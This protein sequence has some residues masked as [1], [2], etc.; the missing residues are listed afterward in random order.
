MGSSSSQYENQ[1]ADLWSVS[2]WQMRDPQ[3]QPTAK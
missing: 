3:F 1:L 2:L